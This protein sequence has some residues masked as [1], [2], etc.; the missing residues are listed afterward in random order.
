MDKTFN[1]WTIQ[2]QLQEKREQKYLDYKL[3]VLRDQFEP[4]LPP[5]P[6]LQIKNKPKSTKCTIL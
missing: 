5:P 3:K 1:V 6:P 4:F 2:E